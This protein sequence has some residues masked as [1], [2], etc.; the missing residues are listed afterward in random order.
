MKILWEAESGKRID[1]EPIPELSTRSTISPDGLL[2]VSSLGN[3]VLLI[4]KT[5]EYDE[6][7]A[8]D[9]A[10]RKATASSYHSS[11]AKAAKN[12]GDLFAAE[13]HASQLLKLYAPSLNISTRHTIPGGSAPSWSPD[14]R[15]IV[16]AR[17]ALGSLSILD[18]ESGETKELVAG[19]RDAFWSPVPNGPIA[20]L[21][22]NNDPMNGDSVWV[23]RA[24]GSG[25]HKVAN[26][27]WLSWSAD[28]KTLYF[29]DTKTWKLMAAFVDKPES[30]PLVLA[31]DVG[32]YYPAVSPDG[33]CVAYQTG[34]RFLIR[35]LDGSRP[36]VETRLTADWPH[37]IP[38]WTRDGKA[39]VFGSYTQNGLWRMN[40][41]TGEMQL[42]F[43]KK[44]HHLTI[45]AFSPDGR[46]LAFDDRSPGGG[47]TVAKIVPD[48]AIAEKTPSGEMIL[49]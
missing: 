27:G 40:A 12:A 37:A 5:P 31:K 28:G 49:Y 23:I 14:G 38:R 18:V 22:K 13:F 2:R 11:Q 3:N 10:R 32:F 42:L 29:I 34:D 44:G 7:W 4:R 16:Y 41:A 47:V 24:D 33:R 9:A 39:V 17:Q 25:E 21:R 30:E 35:T 15:H 36:T 1:N 19:G 6:L 46:S 20:F 26:G 48:P 43:R 45:P 8:E